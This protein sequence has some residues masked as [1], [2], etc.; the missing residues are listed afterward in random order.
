MLPAEMTKHALNAFLATTVTFGNELGNLCD[1]A[2]ADA[3][4]VA[5]VLRLEPRIGSKAMLFPGLGFSGGTLA[6]DL[7]SL[8]NLGDRSGLETCLLDGVWEANRRQNELVCRKL[9]RRLGSLRDAP[10]AIL[11]LTYK[12]GTSTLRRSAALEIIADLIRAGACIRAHDPRAD[13]AELAGHPEFCFCEDVYEAVE[14]CRAAVII[15]GWDEYKA[16]DFRH[17]KQRMKEA[18]VLDTN[19]M[20]DRETLQGLGFVYLDVGRGRPS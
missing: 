1:E 20:L 6:R 8:R 5:E 10:I 15:T 13:R 18:V 3:K 17:I 14:G 7:Q 19:N 4:R 2:G 9:T 11:G 12:P 16:L